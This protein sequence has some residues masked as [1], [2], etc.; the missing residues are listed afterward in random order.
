MQIVE[1]TQQLSNNRIFLNFDL[2]VEYKNQ[3]IRNII[4]PINE[5]LPMSADEKI[6]ETDKKLWFPDIT[7][8]SLKNQKFSREDMYDNWGR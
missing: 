6:H 1:L 8:I 7:R 4:M 2:P 3:K 5:I